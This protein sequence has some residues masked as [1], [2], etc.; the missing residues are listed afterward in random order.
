MFRLTDHLLR[1]TCGG[2]IL[3]AAQ[4]AWAQAPLGPPQPLQGQPALNPTGDQAS[5]DAM[6]PLLRGPV[7][8][9]FAEM[10][11]L[12][13]QPTTPV[14][15]QPPQP[16]NETP[17][18]VRP[19]N[20]DAEWLPGYWGWDGDSK[21]FIWISGTWRVPP[22]NS[23]WVPGYW[24]A[25]AAGAQ[26]VPGFWLPAET[27]QL[28][29]LPAP[30]AYQEEGVDASSPPSPDVSWV[31]GYWAFTNANYAWEPGYWGKAVQGW[32]W[33]AP[34]YAWTPY[35][36]VFV[37]GHWDLPMEERGMLFTPVAF[38]SPV[39]Q[40][41]GFA[42]TPGYALDL[43]LLADNLFVNP[44]FQDYYFGDYYG[45]QYQTAGIYPWYAVGTGAYLYDPIFAYRSWYDRRRNPHWRDDLR[46]R[47]TRLVR[48]RDLRPPRT[49][50]DEERLARA[51]ARPG[52]TYRPF[53]LP[54][55]Q[56][57]RDKRFGEHLVRLND[58][59]RRNV[60]QNT[61]VRRR[62]AADRMRTEHRVPENPVRREPRPTEP[63]P[64]RPVE[65]RT[66]RLPAVRTPTHAAPEERERVTPRPEVNRG[67]DVRR[68]PR[69]T[70]AEHRDA[71]RAE[72]HRVA[73]RVEENRTPRVQP[74]VSPPRRPE[75]VAV[76]HPAPARRP[77]PAR[78]EKRT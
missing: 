36:Y 3:L 1:L 57:V 43:G 73:P 62:L 65:P 7:H 42:Y 55:A 52:S 49:W 21:H 41:P 64:T 47:Y 8:E 15:G 38:T 14:P 30:P 39:W 32:I 61:E 40:Q 23:R 45:D 75:R 46:Q 6:E 58:V 69:P 50:R 12:T 20:P 68:E 2:I 17:A 51:S 31:P 63:R 10:V 53:A 60:R 76:P 13:P 19:D 22:P 70:V 35:G 25:T 74:R 56:A 78:P 71:P 9:G 48:D 77:A 37:E 16:I 67:A 5:T 28:A 27:E 54:V 29:Y 72:E 33:T 4:F 44:A 11:G 34:H 59:E 26:R 66:F 18:D 24:T